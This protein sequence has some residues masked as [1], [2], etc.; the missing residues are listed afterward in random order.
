MHIT[1]GKFG[2]AAWISVL[3]TPN[4]GGRVPS[5]LAGSTPMEVLH[6]N[7]TLLVAICLHYSEGKTKTNSKL[8]FN[9]FCID[10]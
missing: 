8:H 3:F 5:S 6:E 1:S 7:F 9:F 4:Y 10:L 2:M